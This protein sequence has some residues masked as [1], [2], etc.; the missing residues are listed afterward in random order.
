MAAE[1]AQQAEESDGKNWDP[2]KLMPCPYDKNHQI[3]ACRFPYHLIK[4]KKNHPKLAS[5]LK[6]CPY[7]A[8]HLVHKRELARHTETCENRMCVY[9]EDAG[10]TNGNWHVPVSTWVN[11]IV[12]ED[13]DKEADE[14]AAPFVWGV[15]TLLD[16]IQETRPPNNLGPSFRAPNTLPWSD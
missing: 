3:R 14:F 16:Q 12:I 13:W 6:T 10:S 8:R 15:N 2:D 7:N 5:E 1:A 9:T 11:P 4:C